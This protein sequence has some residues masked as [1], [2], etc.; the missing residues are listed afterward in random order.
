MSIYR[1]KIAESKIVRLEWTIHLFRRSTDSNWQARNV[2]DE[3]SENV[4]KLA[5]SLVVLA[6]NIA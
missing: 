4:A 5:K 1:N 2:I 6:L 3:Y